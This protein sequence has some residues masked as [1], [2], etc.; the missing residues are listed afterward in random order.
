MDDKQLRQDVVDELEWEPSIDAADIGVAVENGVVTLS[1][2]VGSYAEKATAERVAKRVRGVRGIAQEIEV[3]SPYAKTNAD[4]EIAKRAVDVIGWDTLLP[5]NAIQVKVEGGWLTLSGTVEW[6]YQRTAAEENVRKLS[7]V[8]GVTN[9]I[10]IKPRPQ[11]P[12]IKKRIE[13]A[14]KRNAEIEAGGIRINVAGDKVTLEGKV[15]A[16]HEREML[17]TAVWAAPGVG[18]VI[19]RVTVG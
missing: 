15:R 3:R 4:D 18:Q 7:G 1:G 2:H 14:L 5:K 12:D 9:L 13:D 19:D 11:V 10:A 16:W 17:E 6:Q 8:L